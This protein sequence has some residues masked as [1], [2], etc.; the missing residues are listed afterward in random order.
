MANT[1]KPNTAKIVFIGAGSAAFGLSLFQD[2]FSTTELAG[3]TLT[4]VDTNPEAL[5]RMAALAEVMNRHGDAGITI[6][7]TTDRK[8]ALQGAGF[9]LCA[10]AIDRNRL[11]RLDFEVPKKHGI[12]HTL[13]ENGGPGGLFF[14]LRTLP[15]IVDIVRD[16]EAICPDAL[17]INLSN[18][19]SRIVLGLSR[20]TS[21]R[22]LGLC[23]GIF[24]ARWFICQILG[25]AEKEVDVW[26][27]GLNHFQWLT[28]IREKATGRD[29][30]PLL[31]EKEATHDPSFTPLARRLFHAFGLWV[32]PSDDHTGEYLPY[33]WEA[34]EHGFDFKHD[35]EG[36]V[37]LRD[38]MDGVID[39]SKPIPDDWT[40]PSWGERAV[41]VIAGQLHNQKRFIESGIVINR[42]V[43]PGLP[44]EL[45]VEVPLVADAAGIHPI[46]LGRL[47]DGIVKLLSVQANVQQLSVEAALRGSKELALQ[48][49]LIDPV[50]NS[51]TAAVAILDE[52]WEANRPYIRAC[53]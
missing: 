50:I 41:A 10:I 8:A 17:F 43:I 36:R 29:L 35:E 9:V 47:P 21:V 42:G 26:G 14:T 52:L 1:T 19:E 39:G 4:L 25:M 34:G 2:L 51:S 53:L 3:S 44:D 38:L 28:A 24:L 20:C 30:Y 31:R 18:P 32:T 48:A 11:W 23:H 33:G 6:E 45:A 46:S 13:G 49:L 12:R 37:I 27:A 7:K 16:V 15:L 5:D 40:K 22:T